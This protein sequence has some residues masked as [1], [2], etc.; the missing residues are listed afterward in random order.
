MLTSYAR[1]L[2][3]IGRRFACIKTTTA[4]EVLGR[5]DLVDVSRELL[6]R[7]GIVADGQRLRTLD[8]I[9]VASASVAGYRLEALVTYD[10]RIAQ[11]AAA[12]GLPVAR[13]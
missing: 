7:A 6:D 8:A 13:P 3:S 1:S 12:M 11:A 4:R 2:Q 10:V 9:H 5:V